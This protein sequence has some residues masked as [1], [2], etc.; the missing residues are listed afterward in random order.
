MQ[1]VF[2][3]KFDF[4]KSHQIRQSIFENSKPLVIYDEEGNYTE[5][6]NQIY[7]RSEI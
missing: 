2:L 3:A 4:S 7:D 5:E 6:I 1:T